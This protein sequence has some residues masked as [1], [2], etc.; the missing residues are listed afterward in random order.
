M[1]NAVE[2][3]LGVLGNPK[4]SED[5][6]YW[7]HDLNLFHAQTIFPISPLTLQLH[8]YIPRVPLK[9]NRGRSDV[10][11]ARTCLGVNFRNGHWHISSTNRSESSPLNNLLD[12]APDPATSSHN[13]VSTHQLLVPIQLQTIHW[14][15]SKTT[16]ISRP[17]HLTSIGRLSLLENRLSHTVSLVMILSF[18]L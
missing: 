17:T 18:D 10:Y 2:Q 8:T 3:V 4:E 14:R 12:G 7:R 6:V 5:S 13:I 11:E 1:L 9:T 16:I 15:L